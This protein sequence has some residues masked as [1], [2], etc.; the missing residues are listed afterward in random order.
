[1]HGGYL[2]TPPTGLLHFV[3]PIAGNRPSPLPRRNTQP[4]EP[5]QALPHHGNGK[6]PGILTCCKPWHTGGGH[7]VKF[8][9]CREYLSI[10]DPL[11]D[12]PDPSPGMQYEMHKDLTRLF[13]LP[14]PSPPPPPF[15]RTYA[16]DS[17]RTGRLTTSRVLRRICDVT[18]ASPP[19]W[20]QI[21]PT[22]SLGNIPPETTC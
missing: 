13:P 10:F 7:F 16:N 3:A 14:Q 22:N 17:C 6:L 9:M 2:Q 4:V 20:G 5:R 11:I 8:Y 18:Y 1:M 19:T 15:T 12:C 21:P